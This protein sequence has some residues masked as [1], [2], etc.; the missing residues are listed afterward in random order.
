MPSVLTVRF[1]CINL[2]FRSLTVKTFSHILPSLK[3]RL[4][5]ILHL[6]CIMVRTVY[7]IYRFESSS[8]LLVP[9]LVIMYKREIQFRREFPS[10]K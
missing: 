4:F 7:V 2:I 3:M 6:T 10:L 9:E 8:V 1:T 5:Y